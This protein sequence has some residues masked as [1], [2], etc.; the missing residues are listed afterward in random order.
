MVTQK[1]AVSGSNQNS[2][3]V[4]RSLI[5]EYFIHSQNAVYSILCSYLLNEKMVL[6]LA[7]GEKGDHHTKS[8]F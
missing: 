6:E 5:H 1:H 7:V 2:N 3:F 4:D 8:N